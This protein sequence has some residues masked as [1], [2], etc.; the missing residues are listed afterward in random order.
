MF[1][2]REGEGLQFY[3]YIESGDIAMFDA[4]PLNSSNPVADEIEN[5]YLD[6]EILDKIVERV[7]SRMSD[8]VNCLRG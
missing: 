4:W 6:Q 8:F 7:N 3:G 1:D 5:D 2:R